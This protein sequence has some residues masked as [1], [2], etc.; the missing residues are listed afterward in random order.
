MCVRTLWYKKI[1]CLYSING[2]VGIKLSMNDIVIKLFLLSE[3]MSVLQLIEQKYR[4]RD[5]SRSCRD[6]PGVDGMH[7][8]YMK[9]L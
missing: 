6:D 4:L 7:L 1:L 2:L 9:T 8:D 5:G 3:D